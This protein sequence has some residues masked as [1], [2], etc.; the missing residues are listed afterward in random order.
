MHRRGWLTS[1][2]ATIRSGPGAPFHGWLFSATLGDD[3]VLDHD[4]ENE[5]DRV[6]ATGLA[7][8]GTGNAVSK[9]GG[10]ESVLKSSSCFNMKSIKL[11]GLHN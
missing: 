1:G 9:T 11:V 2:I 10:V 6:T 7:F 3:Q 4:A 8:P 5:S